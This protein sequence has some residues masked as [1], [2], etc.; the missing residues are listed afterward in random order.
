MIFQFSSV[1]GD[2]I[3]RIDDTVPDMKYSHSK[4]HVGSDIVVRIAFGY[5]ETFN[6]GN[7]QYSLLIG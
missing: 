2:I 4:V 7:T 6:E 1:S 5:S 3:G